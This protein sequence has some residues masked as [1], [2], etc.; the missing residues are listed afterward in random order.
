MPS[1]V[2]WTRLSAS[3]KKIIPDTHRFSR[4]RGRGALRHYQL[5]LVI[6]RRVLLKKRQL[7]SYAL[8]VH[9]RQKMYKRFQIEKQIP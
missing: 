6:D 7:L 8:E 1:A 2:K 9:R 3:H 4:H 5:K